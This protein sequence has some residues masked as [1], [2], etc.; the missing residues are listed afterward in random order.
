MISRADIIRPFLLPVHN[1]CT[2]FD[3]GCANLVK[4]VTNVTVKVTFDIFS[5]SD[6]RDII[7]SY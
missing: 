6:E 1:I 2:F 3:I 5:G 7:K 4:L